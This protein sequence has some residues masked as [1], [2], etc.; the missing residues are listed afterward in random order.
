M[1]DASN[2]LDQLL[3]LFVFANDKEGATLGVL[4]SEMKSF[5]SQ[6]VDIRAKLTHLAQLGLVVQLPPKKGSRSIKWRLESAGND[7]LTQRLG[8]HPVRKGSW[9][10][11]AAHA[12]AAAHALNLEP[13]IAA[14]I[15]TNDLLAEYFLAQRLA[16]EFHTSLTA[17]GIGEHVAAAALGTV[18]GKPAT[19]WK[20]LFR[21]ALETQRSTPEA[22]DSSRFVEQVNH[23]LGTAKEGWFGEHKLFI[24]RAWETWRSETGEQLDLSAFKDRLLA[25]L[26]AGHLGLARADFTETL[27]PADLQQ[28]EIRDG[29]EN[30]HFI[31]R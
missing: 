1:S 28:A 11:K 30:F 8:F 13:Q 19:L 23:T 7:L 10:R 14:A 12:L 15:A 16:L 24:H 26:R 31:T 17:E 22:S 18:N 21:R 6:P 9:K 27:D 25:A 5:H 4:S 3:L 2:L 29:E 20:G